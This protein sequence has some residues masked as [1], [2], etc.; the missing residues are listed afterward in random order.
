MRNK[1]V[2]R[3]WFIAATV[4]SFATRNT[5]RRNENWNGR[6]GGERST[7]FEDPP[8]SGQVFESVHANRWH[9]GP[10][11]RGAALFSVSR[12]AI[13]LISSRPEREEEKEWLKPPTAYMYPLLRLSPRCF[14][15]RKTRWLVHLCCFKDFSAE[16]DFFLVQRGCKLQSTKD[17]KHTFFSNLYVISF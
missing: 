10:L 7:V 3:V 2:I 8:I 11:L 5:E 13:F 9:E 6:E 15:C 1:L 14:V 17:E 4:N 16:E 12:V